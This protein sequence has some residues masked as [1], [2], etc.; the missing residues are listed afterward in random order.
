MANVLVERIQARMAQ[1]GTNSTKVAMAARLGKTAV[2]DIIAGKSK[3]P[4]IDT[5]NR[6]A[7]ALEC[8]M[9]YLV[10]DVD[11]PEKFLGAD[12]PGFDVQ[13]VTIQEIVEAGVFKR[14][15]FLKSHPKAPVYAH[16]KFPGHQMQAYLMGDNS[17]A[18]AGI[19]SGDVLT[20][21]TPAG[22]EAVPLTHG[23]MVLC[24]RQIVPPG[25]TEVSLREVYLE[26]AT[27]ILQTLPLE[28]D[29][30]PDRDEVVISSDP[31]PKQFPE[32]LYMG[33]DNNGI[34]IEGTLVRVI[35]DI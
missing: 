26:D 8:S 14:D 32:N 9:A 10:G 31:R 22:K 16:L 3:R 13:L 28:G 2:R 11:D 15:T 30:E 21:A 34:T 24:V 29:D 7:K 4:T 17:M 1:L 18:A 19:R 27:I 23:S 35:R 5:I 20:I 25:I 33:T 6:I 12:L